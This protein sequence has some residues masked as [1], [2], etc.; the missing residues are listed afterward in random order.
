VPVVE[1]IA[2]LTGA[3]VSIDRPPSLPPTFV[4]ERGK[5]LAFLEEEFSSPR[6]A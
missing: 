2:K 4:T 1:L 3:G 5:A 6:N